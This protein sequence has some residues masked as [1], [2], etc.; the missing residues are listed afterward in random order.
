MSVFDV[1]NSDPFSLVS[2]TDA[3]N[4]VPFIPGRLGQLGI[5]EEKPVSTTAVMLEEEDGVLYLVENRPR[6]SAPQQNQTGK[7]KARSLVLTHLPTGDRIM[8]DEIQGVR[9]FGSNDQAKAILNVT[10]GRLATMSSSL[11]ATLEHLRIGAIKGQIL[12][13]DGSTVIYNLFTEFGVSQETEVDFDLDNASPA[14]GVLRKKC[15]AIVR[16]IGDNLGATPFSGVH[17]LCGDAFFDDLLAHAEVVESYKGTPM[18]QVLREGYIY[19]NSDLKIYGAFEFG[20]IVFEN[21]RGKVGSIDYIHT[22][23]AHFFPVGVTGLFKTYFGPANY[24]ETVNTLGLPK[25]AKV[26]PDPQ[27]QKWVDIEAQSNPLPIC[28]RPKVLM[29]AKRT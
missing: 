9:E 5:F 26:S 29:L 24:I 19:P 12:D 8:A 23:K 15:A 20:G 16:K 3:I 22:D 18:A 14:S 6:G 11:D 4:K 13:S 28:T 10:N 2:L 25:Y 7:R 1:F 27:F 17:C 21:Y